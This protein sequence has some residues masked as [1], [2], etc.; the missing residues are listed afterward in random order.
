MSDFSPTDAALEGFRITRERPLALII[1]AVLFFVWGVIQQAA[2]VGSGLG[3]L[4]QQLSAS[5]GNLTPE[6]QKSLSPIMLKSLPLLLSFAALG[7]TFTIV[8]TTAV[9]RAVLR[10]AEGRFGYLRLSIDEARQLGLLLMI[11]GCGLVYLFFIGMVTAIIG[12]MAQSLGGP[13]SVLINI[14]LS[15]AT[16]CALIYPTVR[17]SLAPAMTFADGRISLFRSW[18]LT[19]NRFWRLS[20]A[21]A[22]ALALAALVFILSLVIFNLAATLTGGKPADVSSLRAYFTP[23][24]WVAL[25]FNGVLSALV[26]AITVSP[27]AAAFR[28]ISGRV[29]APRATSSSASPWEAH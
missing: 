17:L 14:I 1:W 12:G 15:V 7:A 27:V 6:A 26:S 21:Y 3:P 23:F 8:M 5:F 11:G 29:G 28:Q 18:A 4:M 20:G 25:I 16:L 22:M 24:T 19:R 10:P 13:A 2:L 9:F